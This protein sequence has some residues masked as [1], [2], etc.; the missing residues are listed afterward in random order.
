MATLGLRIIKRTRNDYLPCRDFGSML[1]ASDSC[2]FQDW[3][4]RPRNA[5]AFDPGASPA[6]RLQAFEEIQTRAGGP[7]LL[8]PAGPANGPRA[9]IDLGNFPTEPS[10]YPVFHFEFP[11]LN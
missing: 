2:T 8:S 6:A 11:D 10:K 4:A 1:Y 9:K 3:W 7:R 5:C